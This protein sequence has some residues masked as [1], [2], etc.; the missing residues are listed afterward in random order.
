[1]YID[2]S[3]L[4]LANSV[5]DGITNDIIIS[6]IIITESWKKMEFHDLLRLLQ[7][8]EAN[9]NTLGHHLVKPHEVNA[10]KATSFHSNAADKA[11]FEAVKMWTQRTGREHR[12]WRTL[13]NVA[14]KWG[15]N[16]VPQFLKDNNLNG[17]YCHLIYVPA[18]CSNY[19][20]YQY[21]MYEHH[22]YHNLMVRPGCIY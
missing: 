14:K 5:T 16:T 12:T 11:M 1:M 9:W 15:D 22:S 6:I 7:P 18:T 3:V 4:V 19:G 20:Y 8:I 17:E 21:Q 10:I 13:L 2:Y